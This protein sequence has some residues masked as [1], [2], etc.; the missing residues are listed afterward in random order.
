MNF[1]KYLLF[2]EFYSFVLHVRFLK[3]QYY[4]TT[5]GQIG[6]PW[7]IQSNPPIQPREQK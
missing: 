6:T 3:A 2:G 1:H 4:V 5:F 7:E